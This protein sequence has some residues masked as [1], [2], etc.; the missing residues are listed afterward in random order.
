MNWTFVVV[1]DNSVEQTKSFGDFWIGCEY[2]DNFIKK[3]D[4]DFADGTSSKPFPA[5]NRNESYSKGG[6]TIGL[7]K[8]TI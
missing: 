6:L 1:R 2:T 7:Y 4:P 8:D 3:I 5:Y